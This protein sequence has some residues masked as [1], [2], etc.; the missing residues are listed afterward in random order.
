[1][2]AP[3]GSSARRIA[4][5]FFIGSLLKRPASA[6]STRFSTARLMYLVWWVSMRSSAGCASCPP[7]RWWIAPKPLLE[8]F[9]TRI[10]SRTRASPNCVRWQTVGPSTCCANSAPR[11]DKSSRRCKLGN[12]EVLS[13]RGDC[14]FGRLPRV[15]SQASLVSFSL[16]AGRMPSGKR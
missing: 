12:F 3:S 6:T 15:S 5:K 10:L 1:M 9:W 4:G 14:C 16:H 8:R 2:F 7:R 11:A 13:S